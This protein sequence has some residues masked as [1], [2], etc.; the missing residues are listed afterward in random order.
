M[1]EIYAWAPKPYHKVMQF[2][3]SDGEDQVHLE[4]SGEWAEAARE[5]K[6]K[7]QIDEA[8]AAEEELMGEDI[9]DLFTDELTLEA[10]IANVS[11][12]TGIDVRV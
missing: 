9:T 10:L 7:D 12:D 4:I 5:A 1:L 8:K 6:L 11:A 3:V 2:K